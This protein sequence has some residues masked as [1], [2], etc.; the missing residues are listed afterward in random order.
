M[1]E[2]KEIRRIDID[3]EM[4]QSYLDYAMSV[5]VSRALPDARDGL[6]PVQRRILYAMYDLGLGANAAYKKSAR[7]VGEVL[8]KYHPHGDMAVYEA[9]AR[10]AQDF[11]MR[12][13]LV[14]GQGNF[15][16]VDG[17]PPAAMRYTEARLTAAA[18]E[19]LK[20]IDKDTVAFSANFDGT[21]EEPDVLPASIPNLLVN[22]ATGIAVGMATNIPPH[23]LGEVVDGLVYMLQQW[24]KLDDISVDDL[25]AFIKG[26]DFPTGG[27]IIQ[28]TNGEGLA[29]IYGSGKGKVIV[30]ARA[31]MEEMDR[32]R[33]RI[34]IS[35]LPYMVN[36]ASLIERI[37]ELVREGTLEGVSDLRDESDR[38]GLRIVIELT[39]NIDPDSVLRNLYKR[40]QMQS[41]FGINTLALVGG[42]PRL[43]TLK[44]ALK[45]FLDHRLLVIQ[46]RSEYDLEK[47]RQR[48]H[49]LE[50]LRIAI[51]HLD[52]II[53][54]IRSSQDADE[55][56]VRL[57]KKYK[58]S[59]IQAQAILDMPLKR[60]AALERKK[61]E[62]EYREVSQLIRMLEDLL[63]SPEK[64]R[65]KAIEELTEVKSLYS[66]KRKTQIIGMKEGSNLAKLLTVTDLMESEEVWVGVNEAGEIARTGGKTAPWTAGKDAAE[67]L[68]HCDTHHTLYL[69]T[70]TGS[71]AAIPVHS[72]PEAAQISDGAPSHKISA[73]S[74]D[75][76]LAA[77]F[78][79]PSKNQLPPDRFVTTI[80]RG[81]MIKRSVA[82]DLP[83]PSAQTFQLCKVNEGDFLAWIKISTG[84]DDFLLATR[85][86]MCIR[87]NEED[88]RP[89]GL[90]AAGVA[91]IKLGVGDEVVNAAL[92][93][94]DDQVGLVCSD[95]KAKS[96]PAKE[97]P[98]Q[99]RYGMGVIG[100]KFA[101]GKHL[102]GMVSGHK[103]G[104]LIIQYMKSVS[105]SKK[106]DDIPAGTRAT[107]G[108]EFAEVKAG[109]Q[110]IGIYSIT[111]DLGLWGSAGEQAP[112][113]P[114][115]AQQLSLPGAAEKAAAKKATA[116]KKAGSASSAQKT[117]G[118]TG[119]RTGSVKSR[120]SSDIKTIPGSE[121]P[122]SGT[123]QEK[124]VRKRTPKA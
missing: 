117:S 65:V 18:L 80:T 38:H 10:M 51:N 111:D 47:A 73:L 102:A 7:I 21:L 2:H 9:M 119:G 3:Q 81:G 107:I 78:S 93:H 24:K 8:G 29:S 28:D 67:W 121:E 72:I 25:M 82:G 66:D 52:E 115:K 40:T 15:G 96:I 84:K 113:G 35:E 112:D 100:W 43:L 69:V 95:G 36:K 31:H 68:V 86:G 108:K 79:M 23:N 70:D 101:T 64:I 22:G 14:D 16:S 5:I 87:F 122:L 55:A 92:L 17:D 59:E 37:A 32:G 88:V 19:M 94:K 4:Q 114:K 13:L 46:K 99:A 58:L 57:I 49:I 89:M 42:E 71:T 103:T 44:Q 118:K 30:Q 48:A 77:V 41:T 104:R 39:K 105:K 90:L 1:P 106:I 20:N 83:G 34:I 45:V 60:L 56:R 12:C 124:P 85:K 6:K 120:K 50:G 97:F 53:A 123:S 27:V 110:V 61:I 116:T 63:K 98:R 62:D 54:L 76:T 109:D 74:P 33:S 91:G 11:S 26:P 75:D